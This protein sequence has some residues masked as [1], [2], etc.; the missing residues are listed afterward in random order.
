MR[1]FFQK[2]NP[3][4]FLVAL[5]FAAG[6]IG[7]NGSDQ[8]GGYFQESFSITPKCGVTDKRISF[9]NNSDQTLFIEGIAF[10][11]GTNADAH[12]SLEGMK[13]GNDAEIE[14]GPSGG[15]TEVEVPAGAVYVL[16]VRYN[17]KEESNGDPHVSIIDIAY[18]SP[19]GIV[20]VE[21]AGLSEGEDDCPEIEEGSAVGLDGTVQLT[22]TKL[23]AATNQVAEPLT[24]NKG[25]RIFEEVELEDVFLDAAAGTLDFPEILESDAFILPPPNDTNI[26][27]V[28]VVFSD[29]LIVT[30][31]P[32]SGV[33][34]AST[35]SV[36]LNNMKVDLEND[37]S[38][39]FL[40]VPVLTT[41][42]VNYDGVVRVVVENANFNVV[43]DDIA[44][45]P[46]QPDGTLV[47]VGVADVDHSEGKLSSAQGKMAVEISATI[48]CVDE[49]I[50]CDFGGSAD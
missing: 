48:T 23:I 36:S 34:D 3:W 39:I 44:G 19:A 7:C 22:I 13:V 20:Q 1:S 31:A 37:E 41:G 45:T 33:Y 17:P 9:Q 15:M 12:F 18:A 46:I 5:I 42:A 2:K 16:R 38:K 29:T 8:L 28:S 43:G 4:F 32:I 21:V 27:L 50:S 47:I 10:A 24:S 14:Q 35:G 26:T 25:T 11:A 49:T 6:T 40:T 30:R